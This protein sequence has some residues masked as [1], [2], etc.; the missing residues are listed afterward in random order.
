MET[1]WVFNRTVEEV[2]ALIKGKYPTYNNEL[3]MD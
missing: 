1:L 3:F 2:I